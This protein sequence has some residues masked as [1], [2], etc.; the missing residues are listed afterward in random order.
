MFKTALITML[1]I[2]ASTSLAMAS[3][4]HR[5]DRRGGERT[6]IAR[7]EDRFAPR[8]RLDRGWHRGGVDDFGPRRYRP[9]WVALGTAPLARTSR[10]AIE[11]RDPGTFTQLRLQTAGGAAWVE[12]VI[13]RFADGSHQV[14]HLDRTL[15]RRDALL[16][17]Q[18][19]GNNRRIDHI[20]VIGDGERGA[21]E[22]FGI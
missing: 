13:V 22:V 2:G 14:A 1:A 16:E 21:L 12:R 15:G 6:R 11:V 5:S 18:L 20:V 3:D 4:N 8:D 7:H 9:I 17:I 19:D 10:S